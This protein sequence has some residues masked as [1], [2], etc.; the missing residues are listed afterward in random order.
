MGDRDE[1]ARQQHDVL[2]ANV[3][4][5]RRLSWADP[6]SSWLLVQQRGLGNT[7]QNPSQKGGRV[8]SLWR[9]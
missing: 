9:W 4:E 7:G 8:K 5:P 2:E 1:G 6:K 3:A